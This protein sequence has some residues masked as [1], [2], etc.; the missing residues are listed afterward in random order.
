[1]SSVSRLNGFKA[2]HLLTGAPYNGVGRLYF[3][4][5]TNSD[6]IMKGDAV[7]WEGSSRDPSGAPTVA[8]HA[9]GATE[10]AL[11]VVGDI[12]FSGVGDTANVPP[13][14]D[15][16]VPVYRRASTNRYLR[17][18]DDPSIVFEAQANGAVVV[19]DVGQ[20]T[21]I[22]VTAGDTTTGASGMSVDIGN[23][24]TTATL[25]L[26]IIGFP[27]R[28]DNVVGDTYFRVYVLINN[29]QLKGGT[30]TAGV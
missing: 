11:G 10:A 28:P 22:D 6:V 19:G 29:H 4:A 16:D 17:V 20:N 21:E 13:V 7:K 5:S 9:G 2:A 26:K 15:L 12:L 3:V 27:N 24:G 23:K 1:M 30:G 25:P 14:T 18:H 8:R